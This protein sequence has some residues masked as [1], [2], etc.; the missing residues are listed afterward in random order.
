MNEFLRSILD[1]IYTV[2]GNYGWAIIFFTLLI[3]IILMPFDVKSRKSMRKTQQLQPELTRLQKKYANDK[4]KLNQKTMELYRK[5]KINPMSS[6][7]PMLLTMPI[8][9]AMFAAMRMIANEELAKQLFTYLQGGV[10]EFQGWF[11]IKNIWMA[12]SPFAAMVPDVQSISMI[13]RDIWQKVYEGLGEAQNL[14]PTLLDSAGVV[15]PYDFSTDAAMKAIVTAMTSH[16]VEL[17]LYKEALAV[18]PGWGNLNLLFTTLNVYVHYNGFFILPV[19]AALTQILMTKMTPA[20]AAPEGQPNNN[21]MSGGFMKWFFPLFSL[22]IC[23]G[24]NAG[25]S[26]YW[27]A[28]NVFAA[29]QNWILNKYLDAKDAKEK[30]DVSVG[31]GTIK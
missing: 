12:D 8:L 15:I 17:P 1:G 25:F 21:P 11:W 7:L 9:F 27:V 19:M 2:V 30:Q 28:S 29:F 16:M 4:D 31:E 5:N 6:C 13:T 22:F 23:A 20:P 26:L 10:P 3:K 24:Y 14:L 18:V